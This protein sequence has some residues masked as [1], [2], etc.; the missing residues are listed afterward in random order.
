MNLKFLSVILSMSMVA[1][2]VMA[3]DNMYSSAP[4]SIGTSP[5]YREPENFYEA[6]MVAYHSLNMPTECFRDS[7]NKHM[8]RV[9]GIEIFPIAGKSLIKSLAQRI[10]YIS[11]VEYIQFCQ[12]SEVILN[13][14][15]VTERTNY[16]I[17]YLKNLWSKKLK[18]FGED[19]NNQKATALLLNI[20]ILMRY[21]IDSSQ[22]DNDKYKETLDW[23]FFER[24]TLKDFSSNFLLSIETGSYDYAEN[25]RQFFHD[26][27]E[28]IIYKLQGC[29]LLPISDYILGLAYELE[30]LAI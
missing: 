8:G 23:E 28:E 22:N 12:Y 26:I 10:C 19:E 4:A 9:S 2:P 20:L 5:I 14:L 16:Y 3:M 27:A 21:C 1:T 13:N 24:K 25:R 29:G 15:Y 7:Y 11:F 6:M 30:N 17:D 18:C